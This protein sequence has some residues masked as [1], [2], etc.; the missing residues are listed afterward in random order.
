[1]QS[2]L[3][4]ELFKAFDS[5]LFNMA[6]QIVLVTA[7]GLYIREMSTRVVNFLKLKMSDMGRGTEIEFQGKKGQI[8]T[9]GFREVEIH[10]EAGG[11]LLV[12]VDKFVVTPKVIYLKR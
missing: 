8:E 5:K 7:V 4:E 11:Y 2:A 10:L 6:V 1:M 12:P 3:I 9:I